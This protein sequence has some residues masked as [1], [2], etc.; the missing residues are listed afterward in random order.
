MRSRTLETAP[1][2]ET[3]EFENPLSI[4]DELDSILNPPDLFDGT[5]YLEESPT[6]VGQSRPGIFRRPMPG[7]VP[8]DL[9]IKPGVSLQGVQ[10]E[11]M[12]VLEAARARG[13][14]ITSGTD[15]NPLDPHKPNSLHFQG[16]A[17]DIRIHPPN[18]VAF[19]EQNLPQGFFILDEGDHL[20]IDF[21]GGS[22]RTSRIRSSAPRSYFRRLLGTAAQ[23]LY[24]TP[25]TP[26]DPT[27]AFRA[28]HRIAQQTGAEDYLWDLL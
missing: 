2:G 9:Q 11:M 8:G 24:S 3:D 21:R 12:P 18:Q 10:P 25:Q 20:H 16:L 28:G 4:D 22:T 27:G 26:L 6:A 14:V 5:A 17:L 19:Y 7:S 13:D 1:L 23:R 15:N